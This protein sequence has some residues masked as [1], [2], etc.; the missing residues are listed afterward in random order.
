MEENILTSAKNMIEFHS[1][2]RILF[3]A[4]KSNWVQKWDLFGTS[5]DIL[6]Y[7]YF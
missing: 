6:S 4:E 1:S 7:T 3:S 5:Q 2:V